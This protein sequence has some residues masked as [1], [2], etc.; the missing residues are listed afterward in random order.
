MHSQ[1]L[2]DAQ[3]EHDLLTATRN[4]IRPYISIQPLDLPA[5]P[6]AGIAQAAEDLTRL[7]GAELEGDCALRFQA[8]NRAAELQHSFRLVHLLALV[9]QR[10]EPGI[11]GLD[12]SRHV[13]EFETDDRMVDEFGAESAALVGVFHAFFVADAGEAEALDDYANALVVEVC[14]DD[15]LS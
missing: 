3:V 15:W 13:R 12:L 10:F 7:S 8:G 4:S 6:T 2:P 11:R 14:H 9:D 5:L 1:S